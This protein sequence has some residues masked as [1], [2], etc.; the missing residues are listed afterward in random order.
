MK[1]A[2]NRIQEVDPE[3]LKRAEDVAEMLAPLSPLE[4]QVA[5]INL[6]TLVD[7]FRLTGLAAT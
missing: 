3:T 7:A 1:T 6:N 2:N 5:I 4:Q